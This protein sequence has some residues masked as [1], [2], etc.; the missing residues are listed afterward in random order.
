MR[1]R[2]E[3]EKAQR[4][5]VLLNAAQDVIFKQGF[6]QTSMDDIASKAGFSRALLYV[7][8]KDKKDIYQAIK[9]RAIKALE[10]RMV[11]TVEQC[12]TGIDKVMATGRA[13]YEFY[14][15]DADFFNCLSLNISL[16]NQSQKIERSEK[17]IQI[18]TSIMKIMV[19]AL[20]KGIKDNTLDPH[21]VNNPL[22]TALFLRGALHGIIL[23]LDN[24]GHHLLNK[25]KID[26]DKLV[27]NGIQLLVSSLAT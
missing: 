22:A 19:D 18:E 24:D 4:K 17:S 15:H 21:K 1:S 7:Y 16:N 25:A 9:V 26:N 14:L 20:E 8:F 27:H 3:H 12:D 11:K 23:M 2:N 13:Y 5:E 10:D 6:E